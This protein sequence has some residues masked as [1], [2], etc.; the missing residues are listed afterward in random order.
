M[1]SIP[2]V[3]KDI[4]FQRLYIAKL[5]KSPSFKMCKLEKVEKSRDPC[6]NICDIFKEG[7]IRND[8]KLLLLLMFNK[9]MDKVEI[10]EVLR[11]ANI[12]SLH[13]KN[14]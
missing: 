9:I 1:K 5:N 14:N 8:L 10:P 3:K 11:T 6:N 12:T 2:K 13:K 7:V 4:F